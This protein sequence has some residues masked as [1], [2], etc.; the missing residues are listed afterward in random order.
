[1][2]KYMNFFEEEI[3]CQHILKVIDKFRM[4]FLLTLLTRPIYDQS[5]FIEAF[6]DKLGFFPKDHNSYEQNLNVV[7]KASSEH[8]RLGGTSIQEK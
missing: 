3:A 1:M 4:K 2:S 5:S 6:P 7:R 8:Q